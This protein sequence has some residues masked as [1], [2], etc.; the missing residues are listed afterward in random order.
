MNKTAILTLGLI[1]TASA[2]ADIHK[3]LDADGRTVYTQTPCGPLVVVQVDHSPTAALD[4]NLRTLNNKLAVAEHLMQQR[5]DQEDRTREQALAKLKT[6]RDN[7]LDD[8]EHQRASARHDY[9]GALEL[10]ALAIREQ[11]VVDHYAA[12]LVALTPASGQ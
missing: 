1:L 7:E 6:Q 2:Q 10:H 3:C 5:A 8:I 4:A 9:A 11:A 12:A